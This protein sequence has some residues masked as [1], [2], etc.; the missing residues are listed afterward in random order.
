MKKSCLIAIMLVFVI[1]GC[2]PKT[3]YNWGG[4]S[5]SLHNYKKN[6]S[7]ETLEAHKKMLLHIIDSSNKDGKRVPPGVYCE[8][9]YL[10]AQDGNTDEALRYFDRE[11][12]TYPEST[13]FVERLTQMVKIDR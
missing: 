4:Y 13:V 8:Y 5:S 3:M 9:G 10:L 1:A 2:A 6:P 12:K 7:N 11:K